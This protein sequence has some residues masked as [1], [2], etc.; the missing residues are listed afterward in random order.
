MNDDSALYTVCDFT[1]ILISF[2]FNLKQC[3]EFSPPH[4]GGETNQFPCFPQH[5]PQDGLG[6]YPRGNL[7]TYAEH[8]Y[9]YN[10]I[11]KHVLP[12]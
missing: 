8:E 7:M 11:I 2:P 9:I 1:K 6:S 12:P 5:I 4:K 3:Q 10:S